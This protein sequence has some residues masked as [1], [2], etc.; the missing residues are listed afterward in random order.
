VQRRGHRRYRLRVE[1]EPVRI[2]RVMKKPDVLRWTWNKLEHCASLTNPKTRVS[3]STTELKTERLPMRLPH[4]V[5]ATLV[6]T[7][8]DDRTASDVEE[9]IRAVLGKRGLRWELQLAAHRPA[10]P[11]RRSG[12]RIAKSFETIASTWDIPLEHTSSAW[13][14]VAGLVPAKVGCL[15]GLGPV[16]RDLRTP[17]EAVQR[18]G[19]IQRTLLLADFLMREAMSEPRIRK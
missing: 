9:R 14:S 15:C 16:A 13:P 4:R 6:V 3:V 1:G 2:G 7:F 11:E 12:L 19:L 10:M 5:D 8:P 17:H 18:I